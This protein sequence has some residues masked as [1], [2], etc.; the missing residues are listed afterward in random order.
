M[1]FNSF[2]NEDGSVLILTAIF[3]VCIVGFLGF[4]CDVGMFLLQKSAIQTAA[5]CAAVAGIAQLNYAAVEGTSVETAAR[6]A[7]AQNGFTHGQNGVTVTVNTPPSSGPYA[8]TSGYVETIVA[9]QVPTAFMRLF[10]YNSI[11][12]SARAVAGTGGGQGCIFALGTSNTAISLSGGATVASTKCQIFDNSS[13]SSALSVSTGSSL[14]AKEIGVVGGYSASGTN[15]SP[16]PTTGIIP[17]SDP[18]GYL[19]EPTIPGSC[20][21]S[22]GFNGGSANSLTAGCYQ[23]LSW[24][25]SGSLN[26]GSGLYI[27]D[28]NLSLTGSGAV[29]GSNVT[30][31]ITGKT[32]V[33]GG[34]LNL[35][36]P[37]SGAYN[38]ILIFQSR[39]SSENLKFSGM[40]GSTLNGIVYAPTANLTFTGS[41]AG[42]NYNISLVANTVSF[43]GQSTLNNYSLI[44]GSSPLGAAKLVE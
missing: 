9:R 7:A 25:G 23:G 2:R 15:I 39:S 11:G 30:F 33:T 6:A 12:V 44:N 38:S 35:S 32:S 29:T 13:G 16:V 22:Q 24:Q 26:L 10:G 14:S 5:D 4:A 27:I 21:S 20:S 31:Y 37:T 42:T 3:M 40:S 19:Q 1:Q 8:G 18:L 41:S 36:A 34:T 17:T 43:S 28:G